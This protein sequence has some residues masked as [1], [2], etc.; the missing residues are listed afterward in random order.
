MTL[1]QRNVEDTLDDNGHVKTVDLFCDGC[2]GQNKNSIL[3][4]M[5]MY[6]L[7]N[8]KSVTSVRLVVSV[9]QHG[10]NE[11]DS[12]HASIERGIGRC[13]DVMVPSQLIPVIRFARRRQYEVVE[14]SSS[15]VLDW[16]NLSVS[17]GILKVRETDEGSGINWKKM[18][19]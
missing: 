10:Q 7:E 16:K 8:A 6:F 2:A 12:V 11:N 19:H 18:A 5:I 4:G 3:P 9:V 13:G 1:N 15:D 14:L 17:L